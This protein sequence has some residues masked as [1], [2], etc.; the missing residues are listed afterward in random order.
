MAA[1]VA[2]G[3][4]L[5]AGRDR[6]DTVEGGEEDAAAA[7]LG[8]RAGRAVLSAAVLILADVLFN[9]PCPVVLKAAVAGRLKS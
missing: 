8:L 1:V 2:A 5:K 7:G 9:L 4:G 3:L 6:A